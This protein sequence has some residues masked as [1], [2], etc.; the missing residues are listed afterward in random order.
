[1]EP[2]VTLK[3]Q[4][5]RSWHFPVI[6]MRESQHGLTAVERYRLPLGDRENAQIEVQDEKGNW[7]RERN[8]TVVPSDAY[9]KGWDFHKILQYTPAPVV[10]LSL[11]QFAEQVF[12]PGSH[13][14]AIL[15]KLLAAGDVEIVE[16]QPGA[17]KAYLDELAELLQDGD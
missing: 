2:T 14:R 6:E 13:N 9:E 11:E 12:P 1:M 15:D 4:T 16:S 7:K 8:V 10:E 3:N 17:L 5:R